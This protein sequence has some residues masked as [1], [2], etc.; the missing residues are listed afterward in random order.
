MLSQTLKP[1][2]IQT[3][4]LP[5]VLDAMFNTKYPACF[6]QGICVPYVKKILSGKK[7]KSL[8]LL[9]YMVAEEG[10]EPPTT[11]L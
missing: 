2:N 5:Y 10:L 1:T 4:F 3:V 9:V 6:L 7:H 8:L 11:G